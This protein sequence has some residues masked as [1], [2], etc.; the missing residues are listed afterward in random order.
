VPLNTDA[1]MHSWIV[2]SLLVSAAFAE[3]ISQ[4]PDVSWNRQ[5]GSGSNRDS[6]SR[7]SDSDNNDDSSRFPI[8]GGSGSRSGSVSSSRGSGSDS[9][10]SGSRGSSSGDPNYVTIVAALVRLSNT[11]GK[12]STGSTCASFGGKCDPLIYAN[13]DTERPNA[14]W[15]GSKD[16]KFWPLLLSSKKTNDVDIGI[17]NITK[18]YCGQKYTEANL[19]VHVE[20]KKTLSSNAV[21]NDFECPINRDPARDQFSATW[22]PEQKCVPKF[23]KGGQELTYKYKVYYVDKLGCGATDRPTSTTKGSWFGK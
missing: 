4:N 11:G 10:L 19:R 14:N 15:P 17:T 5:S 18:Q 12:I 22:S 8:T 23:P 2:V 1:K 20:D 7:F 21:I 16:V 6:G 9:S 13:L 3:R